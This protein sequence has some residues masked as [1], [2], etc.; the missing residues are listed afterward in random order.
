MPVALRRAVLD[1]VASILIIERHARS[2]SHWSADEYNK[3]VSNG[4]ALVAEDGGEFCGF[5][6]A[7]T[8]SMEWEIENLVVK[9]SFLR[10]GIASALVRE[11]IQT[12]RAKA[13][14]AILLEVRESNLPARALY[15][16]QAFREAGRRRM[17]YKDPQ[18]DA[19][20]YALQLDA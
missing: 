5:I 8:L 19:I 6:C 18:E 17:Y 13:A 16:K 10:R 7:S 12:A 9:Q 15:E 2:A 11:L 20:L 3:L 4:V 14:A 1:D